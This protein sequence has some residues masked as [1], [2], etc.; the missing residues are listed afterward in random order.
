MIRKHIVVIALL[1][2]IGLLITGQGFLLATPMPSA[3]IIESSHAYSDKLEV[4]KEIR[5]KIYAGAYDL[6]MKVAAVPGVN[7]VGTQSILVYYEA[8]ND[9]ETYRSTEPRSI[10]LA[11]LGAILPSDLRLRG[12]QGSVRLVGSDE[13]LPAIENFPDGVLILPAVASR[14]EITPPR[15][16]SSRLHKWV[17]NGGTLFVLG[18]TDYYRTF[19]SLDSGVV[20]IPDNGFAWVAAG[21]TRAAHSTLISEALDLQYDLVTTG[22]PVSWLEGRDGKALGKITSGAEPRTSIGTFKSGSGHIIVFGGSVMP[23]YGAETVSRDIMQILQS[24]ILKTETT[25]VY[26]NYLVS[27]SN[28]FEDTLTVPVTNDS[29]INVLF[30]STDK[31]HL[32]YRQ[33]YVEVG[34]VK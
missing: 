12:L 17:S 19:L 8:K 16:D 5:F 3:M 6:P 23:A 27:G 26:R 32:F 15:L 14:W 2:F 29:L 11:G 13:L 30:F 1:T 7:Q 4:V 22:L 31:Y 34:A 28:S 9:F 21:Q 10:I 33:N 24:G 18:V 25:P 20:E